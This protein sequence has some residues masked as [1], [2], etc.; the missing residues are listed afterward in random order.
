MKTPLP[1]HARNGAVAALMA[2]TLAFAGEPAKLHA[3]EGSLPSPPADGTMGFVVDLFQMPVVNGRDACPNGPALTLREEFM[4]DQSPEE[5]ARLS[6]AENS[7]ELARR[8]KA[9]AVGPGG[10][11]ICSQPDLFDRPMIRTVQSS[12]A[13]GLDL[14]QGSGEGCT[15]AEFTTPLG[16][17]GIDNQEYRALGCGATIRDRDGNG[18]EQSAGL[19]Q[20]HASGEWTQVLLLRG[21]D[22]LENDPAVEVVYGNTPD[23]PMTDLQGNF[24]SG[25][26]YTI[27]DAPPRNRNVL[28][29][30]I[31][32]GVLTTEPQDIV[33]TQTWGQG[34]AR[35][36]RGNRTKY[37]YRFGRLKLTFRPDGSLGGLIGGYRP[38]IEPIQS[39]ALGGLGSATTA[40]IDCAGQLATLRNL[41]DGVRDPA[42]GKCTAVSSAMRINAIQAFVNDVPG[43]AR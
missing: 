23:R 1:I 15:H 38:I 33:L 14:D 24:L 40:G 3:D 41:A 36:I 27:S 29:G 30:R 28:R 22:S 6:L 7:E 39:A 18:G 35:D 8:W 32:K 31:E 19:R 37:T 11:N 26:S 13:W 21:V 20:F 25:A 10:T 34:G 5:R 42:T 4:A 17:T 16:E 2:A 43:A 12:S 9:L